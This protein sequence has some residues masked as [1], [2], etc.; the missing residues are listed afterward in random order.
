MSGTIYTFGTFELDTSRR[1]L[2][3]V[4]E[5]VMLS[6]RQ[7]D[8]LH[9]LVSHAGDVLSKDALIAAAWRDVA[10]TDN[11]LEQA[12]SAIR[13]LLAAPRRRE[14]AVDTEPDECIRTV[15]R[16]GYRFTATVASRP[17]R[18]SHETI[19]A[20]LAPHRVWLEGR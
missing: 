8:I 9:Q 14:G 10:V 1:E 15:P 18:L 5:R 7:F 3:R 13:R 4:G 19:D 17:A 6:D 11:S 16:Q 20:L 12:V 2:R